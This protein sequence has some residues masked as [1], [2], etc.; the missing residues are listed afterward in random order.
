MSERLDVLTNPRSARVGNV[1]GLSRRSA[2]QRHRQ[3][4]VE[5]P[6][7]VRELVTHAP[8]LVRDLY[9]TDSVAAREREVVARARA[10]GLHLHRVSADVA[11]AMS[12]DAQGILAVANTP[13]PPGLDVLGRARLAVLLP[14]V[15]DPGNAG[16]LIRIADAAGAD[17]VVVCRGGVEVTSPKV[18]RASAGSL[19]H[20]PV[21]TGAG[22]GDAVAAAR[23]G[24]LQVIGADAGANTSVFSLGRELARPTAWVF[25]NEA[26][27]LSA[28]EG[29]LCDL[30]ASI[31]IHGRAES[32]NVAAAAAVCLYA[33]A[34][35]LR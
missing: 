35:A 18:V 24:G 13:E 10:T 9:V 30:L 3:F 5:G 31:P 11:T 7:A 26:H 29:A 14:H 1:A 12:A 34:E 21:V 15:A 33:S 19:F 23:S 32:L 28:A 27:G 2:R 4:L 20:L 22:F 6:Q 8:G 25:G 16:T 17:A